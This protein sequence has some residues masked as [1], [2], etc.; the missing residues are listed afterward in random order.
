MTIVSAA[1]ILL[2]GFVSLPI[3]PFLII[4][5]LLLLV[6]IFYGLKVWI[7]QFGAEEIPLH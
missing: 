4:L 7:Q 3:I 1:F 2:L 5:V 6:P